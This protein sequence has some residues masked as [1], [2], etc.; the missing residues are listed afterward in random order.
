VKS[1]SVAQ[2]VREMDAFISRIKALTVTAIAI[3]RRSKEV[4]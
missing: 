4:G 2:D 1:S 3:R